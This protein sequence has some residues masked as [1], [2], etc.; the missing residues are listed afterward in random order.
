MVLTRK[1]VKNLV[2]L[3]LEAALARFSGRALVLWRRRAT[4]WTLRPIKWMNTASSESES[5]VAGKVGK[6]KASRHI[7]RRAAS[8]RRGW[9]LRM[10][11]HD[12]ACTVFTERSTLLTTISFGSPPTHDRRRRIIRAE[13]WTLD[14]QRHQKICNTNRHATKYEERGG[15]TPLSW[16]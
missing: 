2:L 10:A 12:G 4:G 3:V 7:L 13:A 15:T 1:R 6:T 8:C 14:S 16:L 5:T 11:A 9:L